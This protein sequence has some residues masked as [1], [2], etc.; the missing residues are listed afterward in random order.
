MEQMHLLN[1]CEPY[2]SV[3]ADTG[4]IIIIMK[5]FKKTVCKFNKHATNNVKYK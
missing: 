1:T 4:N 5:K 2:V 3:T